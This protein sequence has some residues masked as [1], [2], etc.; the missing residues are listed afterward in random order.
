[1]DLTVGLEDQLRSH[2]R[3][4]AL[5][6]SDHS[7]VDTVP[8]YLDGDRTRTSW[9]H[10]FYHVSDLILR[11]STTVT[12]SSNRRSFSSGVAE[13][14]TTGARVARQEWHA[15]CWYHDGFTE[16]GLGLALT[17][18]DQPTALRSRQA[19]FPGSQL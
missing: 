5:P 4:E 9:S 14:E 2:Q 17:S 16:L 6:A 19:R 1:M 11:S 8:L 18:F 7:F 3:S 10:L 12:G 15:V 13:R